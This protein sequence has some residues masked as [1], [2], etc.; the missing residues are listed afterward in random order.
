MY[1][2]TMMFVPANKNTMMFE[3]TGNSINGV[4]RGRGQSSLRYS[5]TLQLLFRGADDREVC[6]DDKYN[7]DD[8]LLMMMT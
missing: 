3:N 5:V 7:K 6:F 4:Q 1:L 8:W 2:N